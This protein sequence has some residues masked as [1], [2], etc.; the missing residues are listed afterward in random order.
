MV[1]K[2]LNKGTAHY[3]MEDVAGYFHG[4]FIDG[5]K[6]HVLVEQKSIY[7]ISFVGLS[8]FNLIC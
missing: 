3:A 5:V 8:L 4:L 6:M 2:S 7:V 1:A